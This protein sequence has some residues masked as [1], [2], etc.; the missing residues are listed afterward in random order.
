MSTIAGPPSWPH[1]T[2]RHVILKE[3]EA[4]RAQFPHV[5]LHVDTDP[6][7]WTVRRGGQTIEERA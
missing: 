4:F 3:I 7:T 1:P 6:D 5:P 2:L